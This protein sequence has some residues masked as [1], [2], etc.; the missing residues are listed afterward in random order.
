M[1][2]SQ[3]PVVNPIR[4]SA[5]PIC[6]GDED[7]TRTG[8]LILRYRQLHGPGT[9]GNQESSRQS[10]EGA[11]RRVEH[12]ASRPLEHSTAYAGRSMLINV[13]N[14]QGRTN[15]SSLAP[16]TQ[17]P[18]KLNPSDKLIPSNPPTVPLLSEGRRS[19][20]AHAS[21]PNV[22]SLYSK[23]QGL[24][25]SA[26]RRMPA[27]PP[28]QS[29]TT[30]GVQIDFTRNRPQR[31]AASNDAL[32][33]PHRQEHAIRSR[34]EKIVWFAS[35]GPPLTAV[36]M[37]PT[38]ANAGD[39]YVNKTDEKVQVWLRDVSGVWLPVA[40]RHPHPTIEG[41]VLRL[42]D[43]GDPRWVTRIT[44]RTYLGRQKRLGQFVD[45]PLT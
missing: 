7:G 28:A 6:E 42:L 35:I 15:T 44:F 10:A 31:P 2:E 8:P 16:S 43:N 19:V 38:L 23:L 21:Q 5:L 13:H 26:P 33:G 34:P 39:L 18:T 41:Y 29:S 12:S 1:A 37:A 45:A 4:T 32:I 40:E 30:R 25:L 3:H 20:P 22:A 36:P 9:V 14:Q 17:V 11:A 24:S 27:D